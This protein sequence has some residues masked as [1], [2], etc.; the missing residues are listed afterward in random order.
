MHILLL[1]DAL[2]PIKKGL[3]IAR[4][5]QG[6]HER[7]QVDVN[8][9][10]ADAPVVKAELGVDSGKIQPILLDNENTYIFHFI[11]YG[12][13]LK[14]VFLRGRNFNEICMS[15]EDL[16]ENFIFWKELLEKMEI[17]ILN[18]DHSDELAQHLSQHIKYVVGIKGEIATIEPMIEFARGFYLGMK[19]DATNILQ[20]FKLGLAEMRVNGFPNEKKQIVLFEKGVALV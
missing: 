14:Q 13:N 4:I 11:G 18:I 16:A 15:H 5:F 9:G 3:D 6:I 1:G 19:E 20:S 8:G 12:N 2:F 7:I 10:S 17:L